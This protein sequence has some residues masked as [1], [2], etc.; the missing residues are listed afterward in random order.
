MNREFVKESLINDDSLYSDDKS[1][2]E[3]SFKKN[4]HNIVYETI[5]CGIYFWCSI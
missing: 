5:F 3:E 4:I 1:I 2:T